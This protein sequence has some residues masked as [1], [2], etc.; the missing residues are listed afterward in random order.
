LRYRI[1]GILVVS[2]KDEKKLVGIFTTTDSLRLMDDVFSKGRNKLEELS[3]IGSKP[4]GSVA[5]KKIVKLTKDMKITKAIAIMHRKNV[6]TLPV[7]DGDKLVGIIGR[8]DLINIGF[9]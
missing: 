9:Y 7:Y 3:R 1:N 2:A 5:R 8:H 4:V 6:H